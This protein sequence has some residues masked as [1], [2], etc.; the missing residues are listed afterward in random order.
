MGLL[1]T[2][3]TQQLGHDYNTGN[4]QLAHKTHTGTESHTASVEHHSVGV[5]EDEVC[6][7]IYELMMAGR[8]SR[9]RF[10]LPT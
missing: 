3:H 1:H 8:H 5:N 9:P 6:V 10:G 2:V 4:W 7:T